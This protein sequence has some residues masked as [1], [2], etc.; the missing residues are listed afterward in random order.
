LNQL[1]L[2]FLIIRRILFVLFV[3][4]LMV[5]A[6]EKG[7]QFEYNTNW[8]KL[9]EKAKAENKHIFVDC[10]TTWCGPCTWMAENVFVKEEVGEF[11]NANY[12]N[13]KLQF[14]ETEND[15][16][17]V[18]SW[19]DEAKRFAKDYG[20]R[21]YPTFLVFDPNGELVHKVVGGNQPDQFIQRFKD[22][23]VPEKQFITSKKKFEENPQNVESAKQIFKLAADVYDFELANKAF[24][25][26]LEKSTQEELL[27]HDNIGGIVVL[28][29]E[30][31]DSKAFDVI[32]NNQSA[33]SD[34]FKNVYRA[35]IND[36]LAY[37]L[38]KKE[39]SPKVSNGEN[40]D[41]DTLEK[42][43]NTKYEKV[44][45][46]KTISSMKLSN[47]LQKK[48]WK[49][50]VNEYDKIVKTNANITAEELN[51]YAWQMFEECNDQE[52]LKVALAWS[53]LAVERNEVGYIVD[54]YANLLYKLGDTKNA[55]LW[56]EKA[57]SIT[58][59]DRREELQTNLDKMKKGIPTW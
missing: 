34:F 50:F 7:I 33:F 26:I 39:I 32:Y 44:N 52:A 36:F 59:E 14:D 55:I 16:E 23:L 51:E 40:I 22:A 5:V 31:P 1:I 35:D 53:K 12:V 48:D 29:L 10:F 17:D 43:L 38:S 54:T 41:Y 13:L 25:T 49:T 24:N 30:N 9:K 47:Y 2:K 37:I 56:Q 21:A 42:Q 19:Y 46:S 27:Q 57:V 11:F 15:S 4:P 45:F 28:A 8:E 18:K 3:L 58:S 20:V 6:Q